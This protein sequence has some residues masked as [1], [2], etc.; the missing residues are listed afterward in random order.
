MPALVA[1]GRHWEFGSDDLVFPGLVSVLL[2]ALWLI[3]ITVGVVYF[4]DALFCEQSHLLEA[5]SFAVIGMIL[6]TLI[7]EV[8]IV[9]FSARGTIV[10]TKP[11]KLVVHLL[12]FRVLVFILEIVLLIVGTVFAFQTQTE[13]DRVSCPN[14]DRAVLLTQIIVAV[15]WCVLFVLVV[16]VLIYLDPCHCYSAKVNHA[17]VQQHIRS[18]NVDRTVVRQQ[19]SLSH[20]VWE[21]RFKV[22]CCF[23]GSD[24]AHQIAYKEVAEIFAHLFCDTNVVLSD[25]AAGM[26]LLQKEHFAQEELRRRNPQIEE[27]HGTLLNFHN[28]Q[29]RQLFKDAIHFMKYAVGLYSWMFYVY[30]NPLCGCCKLCYSLKCCGRDSRP[31]VIDDNVCLCHLAALRQVTGLNEIDVIYCSFEN[32]IY[33]APFL[34]CLDH[35][36]QSVVIAI[37]GTMSFTDIVTDLTATTRPIELPNFPDFLVHK[38]M[39]KTATWILEKLNEGEVLEDAFGKAPVY[40]L[41]CVGHSLG[42]GCAC[43]LSMLLQDKYPGVQCFCYSPTG[44]L[45]N[46]TAAEYTKT[47]V[48]SLTLGKDLV[49]RLNVPNAHVLKE[50]LVRVLESCEKPKCQILFEGILETACNCFGRPVV[51]EGTDS[52]GRNHSEHTD[53]EDPSH[54]QPDPEENLEI[55]PLLHRDLSSIRALPVGT[56]DQH[57]HLPAETSSDV[58]DDLDHP[59]TSLYPPGR[60]IHIYDCSE[61]KVCFCGRRQLEARWASR[62][63]FDHVIVSPDMV[64]DHFPD[65]LLNAMNRV[66]QEKMEEVEDST[67]SSC[68]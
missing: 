66:W 65:V 44:S 54:T 26:V 20:S 13:S 47:F 43:I 40:N 24:D 23:A 16:F 39:L 10:R 41:V 1:C 57:Q 8:A 3:G 36:C 35:T 64:R 68:S 56:V 33:Q 5:F 31:H 42:S 51:F 58:D 11:R 34:V 9:F 38:G 63:N 60:V 55:T 50:D 48:T 2:R 4:R 12:H 30:M 17:T 67:I 62:S 45:L 15:D 29:E 22:A 37:R 19:W 14:L 21:K 53:E 59:L 52:N 27:S 7:L 32:D 46:Q 49:A 6:V 18:G 28:S 25:I 61:H